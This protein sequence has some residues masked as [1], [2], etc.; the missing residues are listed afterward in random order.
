APGGSVC[1]LHVFLHDRDQSFFARNDRVFA[2]RSGHTRWAETN[3][4]VLLFPQTYPD[5]DNNPQGYWDTEGRYDNQFD[6]KGGVQV[7]AIMAMV[8]R[9]TGGFQGYS[10]VEYYHAGYDHYVL[11]AQADE[12][13]KLDDGTFAGWA[14]TGESFLVYPLDAPGTSNVCRFYTEAFPPS[15]SH[16]YT[17]VASECEIRKGDPKW[18]Y[19]GVRFALR[20]P[21]AQGDCEAGTR[22][23]YRL[24]NDGQ[25]GAPN[26][27]Y[28]TSFAQSD[29][30]L[31]RKWVAEG[32]GV[33]VIGCVPL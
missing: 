18:Q 13:A 30:I 29:A 1:R 31:A 21:D 16:F 3:R 19:E 24:Y 11:V 8:K 23:R 10:A 33:G 9:L 20:L 17:P 15:S 4:I 14:R 28:V 7:E 6:Q 25:G 27:R 26:H 2:E 12:M 5:P 22:P 32:S